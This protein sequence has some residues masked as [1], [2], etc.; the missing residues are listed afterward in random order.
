MSMFVVV[1]FRFYFNC[2]CRFFSFFL[3]TLS[4]NIIIK[5]VLNLIVCIKI[6]VILFIALIDFILKLNN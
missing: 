3:P 5:Y 2:G 6:N 1:S 4:N